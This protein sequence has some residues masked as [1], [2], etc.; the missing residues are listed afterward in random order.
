M[1]IK[2][3]D[4]YLYIKPDKVKIQEVE[5]YFNSKS[6]LSSS[7]IDL[8]KNDINKEGVTDSLKN[9]NNFLN[10]SNKSC[11]FL[12]QLSIEEMYS[13][14][15]VFL[16]TIKEAKDFLIMDEIERDLKKKE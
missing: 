6:K 10:A 15:L 9:I 13:V 3:L 12:K 14:D 7:I 4:S 1:I 16:P 5:I 11:V 8:V 2:N